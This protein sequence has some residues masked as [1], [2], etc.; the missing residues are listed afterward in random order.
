M[1]LDSTTMFE[2]QRH[3]QDHADVPDYQELLDFLNLR[4]QAAEASAEK[5]RVSKPINSMVVSATPTD[6]CIACG[7]EKHQL[8]S[9]AKFRSLSHAGKMSLLRSKNYCLNCLRPGHFV[10]KCRSLNH[11]K[12]C[13][14]PHHTLLHQEKEDAAAKPVTPAATTPTSESTTMHVSVSSNILLMTCQVMV[15]TPEGIVK[16]RALLDTGSSASFV[17]ERLAQTLHLRRFTQ[18]AKICGIAGIPHSDGKQAVTQFLV[19]SAHSPGMRYNVNAF[20]VPQI[21]GNQPVCAVSLNQNWKH[22]EGLVLADPEYNKPGKIDVL[23]GV[24]VFIEVI[25][26]GRRSGPQNT[27]TALNTEFGWILAGSTGAHNDAQLVSTHFTSV[28]T[29]DDLLR[30]FWEVEEK[31]VAN[32]TL[33]L[34]ERCALDHFNSHHSRDKEGRF[35]VPLPKR[36]METKLGESR[37]QAVRRFLSFERSIHP[38]GIF[39]EVQKVV[40]EYFDQQHAE[41]VPQEDLEKPQ[42]QVFYM[43]MHVVRKDSSTTTKVRTVFDA[44]ATTSTGISLNSTLMVGPTVHPPLIDV[45]IRFRNHR[46]AM[47]A[48]VSRMYRAILLTEADKDL[49]R[50]VWR[51]GPDEP[52]RDY[53]MTR[54][55]FGISA[56]SFIANVL[57][58]KCD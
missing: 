52:L 43:P 14:R 9:C 22:I 2:W 39:P 50:F 38:K 30:Q 36:S 34:E 51:D 45:L 26:H 19:S 13:Q 1:K 16:A 33:M 17:T 29:V 15:E 35:I 27:P 48:N 49:H 31:T 57:E 28:M 5:K 10:K 18:D 41:E 6:D 42:N 12:H 37:S 54:L 24:D 25:H 23:L 58:T 40:Q 32:C 8:Y 44:S 55:T 47:I 4:A 11:C 20:I 21:T 3:S 53:R 56:S 46:I 7:Q